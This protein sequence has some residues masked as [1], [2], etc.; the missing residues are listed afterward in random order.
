M[1]LLNINPPPGVVK[2]GTELQQ[3]NAW[4]DA[5]LVRWYEGAL[6]PIGG[7]RARTSS[8]MSGKCRALIAY[9]DNDGDRR[10]VAGTHS[11]LYLIDES[12]VVTDI[13][14]ASFTTGA[15][16]AA[17]NLGYSGAAWDASTWGTPRPDTGAYTPATTWSLDTFGEFVIACST[18]DGK[19]YQW[20]NTAGTPAAVLS[21]APTNNTAAFVTEERFVVALGAG[22]IGNKVSFSDQEASNTWTAAATNQAGSFTLAT[23]GNLISGHRLRGESLLLTDVDAHT[24]R[25]QG[26]PFVYGFRQAGTGCGTTS[27]N[28]CVVADGVAFWMGSNGFFSYNGSVQALRCAVGDFIFN[29]INDN[30]RS[31]V[32]G[33]LN[34]KFSEIVWFYPSFGSTEN[35]SYVSYNYRENIWQIGSMA[36][37]AGVDAGAFR[38]PNYVTSDGYL[39]EHEVGHAY[40]SDSVVFAE[41]GPLQ[42]GSGD[43]LMVARK[44]IPD[45]QTAGDVTATFKTRFYPNAEETSHGPFNM[46]NPTSV[47]FQG[48]QVQMRVTGDQQTGWRVGNMRLDVVQGGA[49]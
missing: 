29:D 46:A 20:A 13:T 37:T 8:A 3:S 4:S 43:N 1:P 14:P 26:P 5:N 15:A 42:I 23:N 24:M 18:A 28:S 47:R 32:Y 21:N 17:Q 25:Y 7:W 6:Q 41:T 44:L 27:A 33:V 38:F 40:D 39:Y 22:G 12:N 16:D 34:S 48:R 30:Q 2:N 35:D 11:N 49:R 19:I 10:V 31:K 36:R 45:E 9:V